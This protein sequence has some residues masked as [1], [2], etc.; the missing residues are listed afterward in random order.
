MLWHRA[1]NI[2]A[3]EVRKYDQHRV[4][5]S[6]NSIPRPSAWNQ[7]HQRTFDQD[8]EEQFA[9]MLLAEHPDPLNMLSVHFYLWGE[10]CLPACSAAAMEPA[11]GRRIIYLLSIADGGE[12]HGENKLERSVGVA[13]FSTEIDCS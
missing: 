13:L 7:K 1:L 11:F 12:R 3:V 8:T 4:I 6:G 9:E 2:F 10:P 5:I